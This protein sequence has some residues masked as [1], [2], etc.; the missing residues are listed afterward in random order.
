[1]YLPPLLL[2]KKNAVYIAD[3]VS[4]AAISIGPNLPQGFFA[5]AFI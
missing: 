3:I 4:L 1:M 5:R 2:A